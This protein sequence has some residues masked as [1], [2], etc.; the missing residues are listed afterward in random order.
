MSDKNFKGILWGINSRIN[1]LINHP[2]CIQAI[3]FVLQYCEE[4]LGHEIKNSN[5]EIEFPIINENTIPIQLSNYHEFF[6]TEKMQGF[7]Q[8]LS[9]NPDL[10][11]H[12]CDLLYLKYLPS[13]KR[14]RKTG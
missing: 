7:L 3:L 11:D 6:R 14:I 10:A 4:L 13:C 12:F 8:H 2:E 5:Q 1:R 9:N